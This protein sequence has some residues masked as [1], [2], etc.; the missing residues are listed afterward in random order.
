M[1]NS[2]HIMDIRTFFAAKTKTSES[3]EYNISC[4][5]KYVYNFSVLSILDKHA[6]D[7]VSVTASGDGK[8]SESPFKKARYSESDSITEPSTSG[9]PLSDN[10]SNDFGLFVGKQVIILITLPTPSIEV[11]LLFESSYRSMIRKN[12][13]C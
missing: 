8:P 3:G 7:A 1:N 13:N 2:V 11:K 4:L 10:F 5:I 6:S 9:S 12:L